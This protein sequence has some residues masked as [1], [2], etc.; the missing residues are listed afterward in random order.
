LP[1]IALTA[2]ALVGDYEQ[3]LTASTDDDL[4]KLWWVRP[5]GWGEPWMSSPSANSI[6]RECKTP[7]AHRRTRGPVDRR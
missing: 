5:G 7:S 1:V 4:S 6:S 2:N 3:C